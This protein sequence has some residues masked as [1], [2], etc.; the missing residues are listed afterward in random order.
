MFNYTLF[1][2]LLN[3]LKLYHSIN[4]LPK[5]SI[6]KSSWINFNDS[7]VDTSKLIYID[8]YN[9]KNYIDINID[10]YNNGN[11]AL[12]NSLLYYGN[13]ININNIDFK[14]V[15]GNND[16][17]ILNY[18]VLID[19]WNYNNHR[20]PQ[21]NEFFNWLSQKIDQNQLILAGFYDNSNNNIDYD[22]IM[23]IIGYEKKESDISIYYLEK[24]LA[25]DQVVK[26]TNPFND[27]IACSKGD[28]K[29]CL[30]DQVSIATAIIG[31]KFPGLPASL[32][33][34]K[35]EGNNLPK[36]VSGILK[37]NSLIAGKKYTCLRFESPPTSS[38]FFQ[39]AGLIYWK[40]HFIATSYSESIPVNGLL[41][42]RS[43]YYRCIP[44]EYAGIEYNLAI[45]HPYLSLI[46]ADDSLFIALA[47]LVAAILSLSMIFGAYSSY[48]NHISQKMLDEAIIEF[49]LDGLETI[50]EEVEKLEEDEY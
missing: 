20:I 26:Q 19:S 11:N 29:F 47:S 22:Q 39:S 35:I 12:F 1:I 23:C 14:Y 25:I 21:K 2:L 48:N 31:N 49:D 38:N 46:I 36:T 10:D 18:G 7:K 42:S 8:S 5:S 40:H 6:I 43:Y 17:F 27:R 33:L 50:D 37:V 32:S 9:I 41:S 3:I 44:S 15:L 30:P 34:N 45:N 28:I 13:Y 24:E 16:K 4:L